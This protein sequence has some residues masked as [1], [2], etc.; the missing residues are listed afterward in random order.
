M[1]NGEISVLDKGFLWVASVVRLMCYEDELRGTVK[2]PGYG[3][4]EESPL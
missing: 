4:Q 1:V 3:A 2:G